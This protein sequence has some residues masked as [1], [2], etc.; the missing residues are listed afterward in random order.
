MLHPRQMFVRNTPSIIP[1]FRKTEY[2]NMPFIFP[3]LKCPWTY[4]CD[5]F[6]SHCHFTLR[7]LSRPH[8]IVWLFSVS[9]AI[10]ICNVLEIHFSFSY[11][12][13]FFHCQGLDVYVMYVSSIIRLPFSSISINP[14]K[15][16]MRVSYTL[17]YPNLLV[18]PALLPSLHLFPI[19]EMIDIRLS[20]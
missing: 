16:A 7:L 20:A 15:N 3:F 13:I 17:R 2:M 4:R 11:Y 5:P 1:S 10:F 9:L 12:D 8:Q 6:N 18:L 19:P 14:W